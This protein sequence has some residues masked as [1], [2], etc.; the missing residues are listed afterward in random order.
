MVSFSSLNP[1]KA[2]SESKLLMATKSTNSSPSTNKDKSSSKILDLSSCKKKAG[3]E[4][5]IVKTTDL[6]IF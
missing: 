5:P 4:F 6:F 1:L 2:S 3:N